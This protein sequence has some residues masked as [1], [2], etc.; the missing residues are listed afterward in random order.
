[1]IPHLF[2]IVVR[3]IFSHIDLSVNHLLHNH[4]YPD[5][6]FNF[7]FYVSNFVSFKRVISWILLTKA[8]D[9]CFSYQLVHLKFIIT[10]YWIIRARFKPTN[11]ILNQKNAYHIQNV[12]FLMKT[13]RK[14]RN[15]ILAFMGNSWYIQSSFWSKS[16]KIFSLIE[17]KI[18]WDYEE[19]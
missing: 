11:F 6:H 13:S 3:W 1:M 14:H 19:I 17:E 5:F 15:L 18:F 8:L 7:L 16:I 4:K 10:Y 2:H 12:D 9:A